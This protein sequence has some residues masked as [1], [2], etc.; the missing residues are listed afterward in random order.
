MRR[1]LVTGNSQQQSS[2]VELLLA[3]NA[4]YEKHKA[5]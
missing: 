2:L 5:D 3:A 1:S 4:R